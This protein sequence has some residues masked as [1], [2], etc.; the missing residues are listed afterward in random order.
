MRAIAQTWLYIWLYVLHFDISNQKEPE[1]IEEDRLNKP[2]RPIPSGKLSVEAASRWYASS[3]ALLLLLSSLWL[4][5]FPEAVAFMLQTWVHDRAGG[6]ST[7]WGKNLLNALFYF[8]GQLGGTRVAVR[9]MGSSLITRRCCEWFFLLGFTMFSTVQIQ[10]F[11]DQEGDRARGRQ[12]LPLTMGDAR[13][14]YVTALLIAFWSLAIPAY[15]NEDLLTTGNISPLVTGG[16]VV[17]RLLSKRSV[18]ADRLTYAYF[19]LFWLPSLYAAPVLGK[20]SVVSLA[21]MTVA[22]N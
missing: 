21:E 8:T 19:C 13:A 15:W 22:R 6:G 18:Q 14:R 20:Y 10:D 5:G 16:L 2:W 1:S 4:G 3:F 9:A 12:T 11:R 7:W 17:I